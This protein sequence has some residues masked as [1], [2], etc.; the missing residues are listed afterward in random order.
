MG[1]G[2]QTLL[3]RLRKTFRIDYDDDCLDKWEGIE[4]VTKSLDQQT[5]SRIGMLLVNALLVFC[6]TAGGMGIVLSAI[7]SDYQTW[8]VEL[9]T[10]V[11][12][13]YVAFLYYR[14]WWENVGYILLLVVV[15]AVGFGMQ[16]Y[17]SSGFYSVMNDLMESVS[18]YF[19]SNATRSYGEKIADANLA[20]TIAM[21]YIAVAAS[22]VVNIF[23]SRKMRYRFL[24]L[25]VFGFLFLP[26]YVH[27]EPDM[28]YVVQFFVGV[29]VTAAIAKNG[30]Y[31]QTADNVRYKQDEERIVYQ[32]AYR[33]KLQ[34]GAC[35]LAV[36]AIGAV[37]FSLLVPSKDY[38]DRHPDS[39]W[40]QSTKDAM[41]N[42]AVL[43]IA[44]LF[45]FYDNT[46]GLTSGKLGG[47]SAV[48]LDY[49]TDLRVTF[50]PQNENR[51]YLRRFIGQDYLYGMNR[52]ESAKAIYMRTEQR[53]KTAFEKNITGSAHGIVKV[54]NVAADPGLYMPYYSLQ[55]D[56][57]T[58]PGRSQIYDYYTY[59]GL[60]R[61]CKLQTESISNWLTVPDSSKAVLDEFCKEADLTGTVAEIV[62]KLAG[63]TLGRADLVRRAMSK[64]KA[65]V[66][67]QER[68]N[69][70]YGNEAEH[71]PGCISNGISEQVANKIYDDM[72][73]FAKYAFNKSHA[74][75]YAVVAYQTAW[76][77]YYYP[78]E[79]MA[80]LMTSVM[81]NS[82]KESEYTLTCRKMNIEILPPDINEGEGGFSVAGNAI[83]YGLSA[84]KGVGRPV[85]E[86]IIAEREANGAFSNLE[87][88]CSRLNGREL[89][90][91]TIENFIKAGAMDELEGTR[92]QKIMIYSA[93]LDQINDEKKHSIAGQM[94][95]FDFADEE[96]KHDF[97]IQLPDVGEF[98][99]ETLL[100]FEKE[101][102]GVYISGHPLEE[103]EEK[104]RKNI[105]ATTNDFIWDEETGKTKVS[106]NEKVI[107]GG[108]ITDKTIKYTKNNKTM[109]FLTLEDLLG[110]V[111]VIVFPR[112]YERYH[113]YLNVDE[114]IFVSGHANVEEDKNGKIIC[115]KIYGFDDTKKEL[116]MQFATKEEYQQME[117]KLF[118]MLLSSDG[119][120]QV[121]IYLSKEKA[122]KRLANNRNVHIEP[123]LL[124]N[125]R[126]CF[127]EDNVKVVEKPIENR[128]KRD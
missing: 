107:V 34:A 101:V 29:V 54:D 128:T 31:K 52:W 32:S 96:T 67:Q 118:R 2:R 25:V 103:Y 94:S 73:D 8:I 74:A 18:E 23:V 35:L 89:N 81:D 36:V 43:G 83:R 46:G 84:I 112:D 64:K 4:L 5:E 1:N 93:I 117:Q 126:E 109:A 12:S 120:D 72:I 63:Y 57:V 77:K 115:E 53:A 14:K 106:D 59:S 56:L 45:N 17:V 70:V 47:V 100:G 88:F 13:L 75:A 124:E 113:T 125:L 116:W 11:A 30:D 95:L 91:R 26:L 61:D 21:S 19:Q 22:V 48:R 16:S 15:F 9:V 3:D 68:Q 79:F 90:K 71:V 82:T 42:V 37:L 69:F 28:F 121:V 33:V 92:K 51:F 85:I 50:V 20:V 97:E 49:D 105:N 110:T 62:Q 123:Q 87:D 58:S 41:Q 119:N 104:W 24:M 111:E 98:P 40:K 7:D 39:A 65:A 122:I 99:K 6:I 127:G 76:L 60:D 108:M 27:L 114:K 66:M 102:L 10:L 55:S 80:S 38:H 44:G 78:V 86:T